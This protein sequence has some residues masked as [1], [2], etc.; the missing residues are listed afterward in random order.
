MLRVAQMLH[1]YKDMYHDKVA[2]RSKFAKWNMANNKYFQHRNF[3]HDNMGR[4]NEAI[5]LVDA[6]IMIGQTKAT[7]LAQIRRKY[8]DIKKKWN[9]DPKAILAAYKLQ[10]LRNLLP[11]QNSDDD[12]LDAADKRN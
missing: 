9:E 3:G 8:R 7:T 2:L 10:R 1:G 5:G 6:G 11:Q 12:I 4:S